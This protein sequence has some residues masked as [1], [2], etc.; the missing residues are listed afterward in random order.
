M[1]ALRRNAE[2]INGPIKQRCFE[3]SRLRIQG[4]RFDPG[5][6]SKYG[7]VEYSNN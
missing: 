1:G 3:V 2:A 6:Y 4:S 5:D 7:N